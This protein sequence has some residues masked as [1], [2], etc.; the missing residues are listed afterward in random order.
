MSFTDFPLIIKPGGKI[1]FM[2]KFLKRLTIIMVILLVILFL[3]SLLMPSK[4]TMERSIVIN[5]ENETVFDLVNDLSNWAKWSPWAQTDPSI[6]NEDA[7]SDSQIGEGAKF[8]WKSEIETVGEGCMEITN[9]DP[10]KAIEINV[11]FGMGPTLGTWKFLPSDKSVE[12]I[13]GFEMELGLNPISKFYGYFMEDYIAPDYEAG[14]KNLKNVAESQ[15][16]IKSVEV[17]EITIDEDQWF[18]SIKDSVNQYEMSK[19][20]GILFSRIAYYMD[21]LGIEQKAP[22]ISIYHFWSDSLIIIEAGVPLKDSV[23]VE[24]SQIKLNKI[25]AGDFITA[26]HYGPYDRMPETYFGINE[27]FRKNLDVTPRGVPW[28]AYI[29]DPVIETNP[30]KW[31]TA[32]YFPVKREIIE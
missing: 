29:T 19:I 6:Y 4:F 8:C 18:L 26:I 21:S 17:K 32:I 24:D 27:W 9:V 14:L 13:W 10:Y 23:V 1:I 15:P 22:P 11:D 12:V 30:E 25:K 28:E 2:V 31:Q 7:F 5:A 16:K 3:V 20:H